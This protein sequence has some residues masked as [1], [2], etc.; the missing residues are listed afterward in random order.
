MLELRTA[1]QQNIGF[2]VV[3]T[4]TN[5]LYM[6]IKGYFF[7]C[8]WG[9]SGT[10]STYIEAIYWPAVPALVMMVLVMSVEQLVE[11]MSDRGNR[12]TRRKPAPVPLC[13]LQITRLD[14][15][16][17]PGHRGG[18]PATA[19]LSYGTAKRRQTR[20]SLCDVSIIRTSRCVL[21]ESN[22]EHEDRSALF[23][24][25]MLQNH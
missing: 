9:W 6:P 3:N 10:K 7:I 12:S 22:A 13:P 16:S 18:K 15:G 8:L 20:D 19:L 1:C 11:W 23:Q 4:V 24:N 14:P 17:K 5:G 2:Y 21:H 25:V